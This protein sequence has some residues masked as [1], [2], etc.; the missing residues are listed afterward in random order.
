MFLRDYGG[1][2]LTE[3]LEGE[4]IK[5]GCPSYIRY[6]YVKKA[7]AQ[8]TVEDANRCALETA[9]DAYFSRHQEVEII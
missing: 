1:S 9:A 8:H 3:N 5:N 4:M 6:T 2:H 7:R